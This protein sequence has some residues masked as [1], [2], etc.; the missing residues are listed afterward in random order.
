MTTLLEIRENIKRIYSRYS[1]YILAAAKF[2]L[3]AAAIS[4][5]GEATGYSRAVT[6]ALPTLILALFCA[7]IPS[8]G[9]CAV[10][11]AVILVQLYVLSVLA[12]ALAA[13]IFLLIFLL[14]FRFSPRDGVLIVL[15]PVCLRLGIPYVVP[16]A[17]GLLLS[18]SAAL[19][20]AFGLVV[21]FA[22]SFISQNETVLSSVDSDTLVESSQTII[23]GI[24]ANPTMLVMI[25]AFSVCVLLVY[26]VRRMRVAYAWSAAIAAGAVAQLILLLIGDVI[27]DTNFSIALVFLGMIVSVAICSGLAFFFFNLD[28]SRI[29]Q[30]QFE[31]DDY[32]YYVKAVPK[33]SLRTR[34]RTVKTISRTMRRHDAPASRGGRGAQMQ[35]DDDRDGY[36]EYED[37]GDDADAYRGDGGCAEDYTVYDEEENH[38]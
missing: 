34:E 2:L 6:G 1:Q 9:M 28:Y 32:Y 5:V 12:L 19:S 16:M 23:G 13:V 25:A 4:M 30:V 11:G 10:I 20:I 7:V 24:F 21:H 3:A 27:Y 26:Y 38:G 31:D 14:Y 18:P 17:A 29:E 15:T 37:Y 33:V 36:D 35:S 8:G 22:I